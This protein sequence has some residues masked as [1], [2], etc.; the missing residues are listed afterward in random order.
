MTGF[1]LRHQLALVAAAGVLLAAGFA[2]QVAATRRREARQDEAMIAAIRHWVD[3]DADG[4][5]DEIRSWRDDG[6]EAA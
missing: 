4:W 3:A 1:L 6:N 5:L 2:L